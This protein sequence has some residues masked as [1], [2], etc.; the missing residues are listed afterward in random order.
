M[1]WCF[2]QSLLNMPKVSLDPLST[3]S[4]RLLHSS[5]RTTLQPSLSR[6]EAIIKVTGY[7]TPDCSRICPTEGSADDTLS[8]AIPLI[9]ASAVEAIVY[10]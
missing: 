7:M 4:G 10:G 3:I 1:R 6:T 5:N 9:H 2:I 8:V